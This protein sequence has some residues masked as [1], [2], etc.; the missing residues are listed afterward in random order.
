V[1][2]ALHTALMMPLSERRGRMRRLRRGISER[3]VFWWV[4]NFLRAAI[5]RDLS[6]FQ[7][8]TTTRRR[9]RW[10]RWP[11]EQRTARRRQ[12]LVMFTPPA[13]TAM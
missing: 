13:P 1:A 8:P 7:R 6:D 2:Q 4:N 12:R 3:T 11:S 5:A 9:T 10:R